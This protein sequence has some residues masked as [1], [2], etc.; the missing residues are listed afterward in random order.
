MSGQMLQIP[1]EQVMTI[2]NP[3]EAGRC[4][5]HDSVATF[6]KIAHRYIAVKE[7]RWGTHAGATAKSIIGKQLIGNLGH[8]RVDELTAGEIQILIDGMVRNNASHSLLSKVVM[9]L[10]AILDLAQELNLIMSNPMRSCAFKL[11]HK[12]RKQK[13]G[14]YLSLDECRALLSELS[15]RDH[16]IVRLFI[17]L[18]VRPE[19]L[20]ALRRNDVHDEFIRIDEVFSSMGQIREARP[21]EHSVNVYVPPGLRQELQAWVESTRGNGEDWLFPAA[22]PRGSDNL[23]PIRQATFRDGVLKRAAKK[24]GISDLDMLTLRRTCAAHFGKTA[25]AEDAHAQMR[26]VNRFTTFRYSQQRPSDSLKSAA[27]ALEAEIFTKAD[28][29][30]PRGEAPNQT[31]PQILRT[32]SKPFRRLFELLKLNRCPQRAGSKNEA[33]PFPNRAGA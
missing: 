12:S 30:G 5:P 2:L 18:G 32:F 21:G 28:L 23:P 19:E 13:S 20:F 10:R 24:A 9:H 15:G 14:R 33:N 11:E 31:A 29:H 1:A 16:L 7:P 17:Q 8:R 26:L 4:V 3:E 22:R 6:E 25:S 27:R